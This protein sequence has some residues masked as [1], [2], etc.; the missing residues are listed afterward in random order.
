MKYTI[1]VV[2]RYHVATTHEVEANSET[3]ALEI[4]EQQARDKVN[5]HDEFYLDEI[6]SIVDNMKA[7]ISYDKVNARVMQEDSEQIAFYTDKLE[8][9]DEIINT[10]IEIYNNSDAE[11]QLLGSEGVIDKYLLDAPCSQE[12]REIITEQLYTY[13]QTLTP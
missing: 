7:K 11:T 1:E 3:E 9:G 10:V 12:D 8:C 13:I 6:A 2:K 5:T 4:A